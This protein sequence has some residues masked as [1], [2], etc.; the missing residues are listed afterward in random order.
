MRFLHLC[1][2]LSLGLLCLVSHLSRADDPVDVDIVLKDGVIHDGSGQPGY[3]GHV[4]IKG[5]DIVAIGDFTYSG[6]PHVIDCAGQIVAPGFI[7]LHNHSDRQIVEPAT[8]A[9]VNFLMQGCTTVV[10][11]NCGS[12]PVDAGPYY[13]KIEEHGAGT[14]VAHLLPHGALRSRVVGDDNRPAT[15]EELAE[16][17]RLAGV[18]MQEG[19]WGMSTGLI[20]VPGCYSDTDELVAISEVIGAAGGIYASHMRN[21]G[22]ELLASVEEL[23]EIGRR[24]KLPVH[25]SHF[26]ASGREAWGLLRQ[27]ALRIEQARGEGQIVTADQYPYIASSTSLE[28]TVIPTWARA[29]GD[30]ELNKRLNDPEVGPRLKDEI[31][32]SI[33]KKD[34]GRA[35]RFVRCAYRPEWTGRSL[36][37]VAAEE[38]ATPVD[39]TVQI[40][41]N[42]GAGIVNFGMSEDD[43]RE[44]MPIPW[45]A[46]ASDGRATLPNADR[47]HPRFYGT[48]PRKIGYYALREHVLTLEQAI[49]SS[50]GLPADILG[51][52]DRG[53]LRPGQAA[54]IV[55]FDPEE[56]I[57]AATFDDPHQY[58]RGLDYVLVNGTVAVYSRQPTGALAGRALRKPARSEEAGN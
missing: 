26:K 58:A 6:A 50:S 45:V 5:K 9:N 16:M 27:A 10:T 35:I 18:A 8:R 37:D 24:A 33:R 54:D 25:A 38:G 22:L 43:V 21:E 12:G 15:A 53:Y 36:A 28:A 19:T 56:F 29:G 32:D 40:T 55:V 3:I 48:F 23:I 46:T 51:M 57:D 14:N 30:K 49:R 47:P 11:G 20:Y 42:G 41:Q 13:A 4:G 31:A 17:K 52:T 1:P 34:D 44:A 2:R 39:I 7:D